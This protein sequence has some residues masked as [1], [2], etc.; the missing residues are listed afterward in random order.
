MKAP[1][2]KNSNWNS[3]A[4]ASRRSDGSDTS[5]FQNAID[6][7]L[8]VDK[9]GAASPF[10]SSPRSSKNNASY[11]GGNSRQGVLLD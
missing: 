10:E 9:T 2:S 6:S 7:I 11:L 5:Q 1:K 8:K 4:N 3:P